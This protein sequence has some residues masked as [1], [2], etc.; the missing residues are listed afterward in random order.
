MMN[1]CIHASC[2]TR[3]GPLGLLPLLLMGASGALH[4]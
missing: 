2:F 4:M 1:L 3:T